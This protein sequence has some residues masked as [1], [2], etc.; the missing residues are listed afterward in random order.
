MKSNNILVIL[1][2]VMFCFGCNKNEVE[3]IITVTNNLAVYRSG[4][5]VEVKIVD[6]NL[7]SEDVGI[8]MLGVFSDDVHIFGEVLFEKGF[9]VTNDQV[10]IDTGR[11]NLSTSSNCQ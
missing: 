8:Y 3:N 9:G 6:L 11:V 1:T 10:N 4:A 7:C 2:I 5:I